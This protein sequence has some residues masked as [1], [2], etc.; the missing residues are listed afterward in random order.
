MLT[1]DLRN[2]KAT[3]RAVVIELRTMAARQRSDKHDQGAEFVEKIA[4][5]LAAVL[6]EF[7]RLDRK[8]LP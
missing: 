7:E 2:A 1:S 5:G 8:S 4:E 6:S 3:L